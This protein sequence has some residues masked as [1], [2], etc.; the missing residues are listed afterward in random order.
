M[1]EKQPFLLTTR[2][3]NHSDAVHQEETR[4]VSS[5][6]DAPPTRTPRRRRDVW[7]LLLVLL[8]GMTTIIVLTNTVARQ[9]GQSSATAT[10][11]GS[12]PVSATKAPLITPSPILATGAFREY[13]LPQANSQVM[14][15]AV[16]HEGRIW[17]GEKGRNAVARFDPRNPPY[18]GIQPPHCRPWGTGVPGAADVTVT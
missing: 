6:S 17:L 4:S 15:L 14:R 12:P 18:P 8:L 11:P 13:P 1:S 9:S 5:G 3:R 7:F 10:R 2:E 16:Y